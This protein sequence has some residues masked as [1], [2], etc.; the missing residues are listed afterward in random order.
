MY[1]D[2]K[3]YDLLSDLNYLNDQ[4]SKGVRTLEACKDCGSTTGS[5]LAIIYAIRAIENL[6]DIKD[7]PAERE[8]MGLPETI[9]DT[10]RWYI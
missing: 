10:M 8:E 6:L 7:D 1:V 3:L 2:E 5:Q 4:Y 9:P